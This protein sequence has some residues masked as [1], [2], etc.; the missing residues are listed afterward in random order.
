MAAKWVLLS[1]GAMGEA[2]RARET[3]LPLVVA[4]TVP[5]RFALDPGVPRTRLRDV[6]GDTVGFFADGQQQTPAV[7]RPVTRPPPRC[8]SRKITT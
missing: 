5:E 1:H 6:G 2:Y 3:S 8:R 4:V 7:V